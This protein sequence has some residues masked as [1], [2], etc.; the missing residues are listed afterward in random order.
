MLTL[1]IW[2]TDLLW[3]L[4]LFAVP[5]RWPWAAVRDKIFTHS[6]LKA[7]SVGCR[8]TQA[9]S[10]LGIKKKGGDGVVCGSCMPSADLELRNHAEKL[11]FSSGLMP[12]QPDCAAFWSTEW[13]NSQL[14]GSTSAARA[15]PPHHLPAHCL[16]FSFLAW[17]LV[18]SAPDSK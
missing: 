15:F 12:L 6:F 9:H 10:A 5:E 18:K 4:C 13:A 14:C 1:L 7:Y 16:G 17:Q 8:K 2:Q 11:G 3:I